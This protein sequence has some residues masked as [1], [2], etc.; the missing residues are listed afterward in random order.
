MFP[1]VEK[2]SLIILGL[3]ACKNNR[4]YPVWDNYQLYDWRIFKDLSLFLRIE[5]IWNIALAS[6]DQSLFGTLNNFLGLS[7]NYSF[8]IKQV[9]IIIYE[10]LSYNSFT[11]YIMSPSEEQPSDIIII[12]LLGF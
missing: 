5:D 4:L 7:F 9:T 2:N 11:F 12:I 3:L 6:M 10:L 1:I 8:V